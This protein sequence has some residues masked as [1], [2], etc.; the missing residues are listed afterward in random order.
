MEDVMFDLALL[1]TAQLLGLIAIMRVFAR[2][3]WQERAIRR[4]RSR[5]RRRI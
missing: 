1:T 2:D 3:E 5:S 4:R